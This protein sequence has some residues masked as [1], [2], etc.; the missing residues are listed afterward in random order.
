MLFKKTFENKKSD[1]RVI[2][3]EVYNIK[4]TNVAGKTVVLR[5][6][7]RTKNSKQYS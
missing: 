4:E 1:K 5:Y 6:F 2:Y 3:Y 7:E